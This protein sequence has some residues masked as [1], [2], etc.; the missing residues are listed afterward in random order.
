MKKLGKH[1]EKIAGL[2]L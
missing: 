1:I 2:V